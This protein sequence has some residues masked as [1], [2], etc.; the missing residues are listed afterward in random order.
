LWGGRLVRTLAAAKRN[1][2]FDRNL[3][4]AFGLALAMHLLYIVIAF[5][6]AKSLGAS[7]TY[8]QVLTIIPVVALF[9]MLPLTINGHGLRELLLIGYFTQMRITLSGHP[10]SGVRE[11]A[12]ALS[13]LL[14]ANDLLWS[15]PG[16][17]WYFARFKSTPAPGSAP[18][19]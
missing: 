18:A 15:V 14:V 11:I 1:F 17:L 7:I 6:F 5:L 8:I 12:V 13:L 10:E 4:A 9:V 16:G 19:A 2:S 3:L